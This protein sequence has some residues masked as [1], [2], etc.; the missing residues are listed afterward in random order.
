[1]SEL[2]LGYVDLL[3]RIKDEVRSARRSAARS[4]NTELIVLYWRIGQLIL[5]RQAVEGWGTGVIGRLAADLRAEFP[6]MRGL[7]QRNLLYMR[8]FAAAFVD[9][10]VQ[11]PV[12]Q[13]PWGHVTVLLERTEGGHVRSWYAAQ[14][15]SGGWSRA[16]LLH[17]ISTNRHSRAGAFASNF[18]ETLPPAES[19]LAREVFHDPYDL[20]FLALDPGY[21]ERQLEDALVGRLTSFIAELG[22]GFSFVGRQYPLP[23]G[24]ETY[25]LDLLFFHLGLRRFVVFELKVGTA[26]PEHLGK[27]NFYVNAVDSLLRREEHGDG[28]TIGILLAADRD[29]VVVE[30]SLRGLGTPLAVST[31]RTHGS[32]PV[33]VRTGL[34][35]Q[36]QL[37][38]VVRDVRRRVDG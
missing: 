12:A 9:P 3:A 27:L 7:S 33:E 26:A 16:T 11:Q 15:V 4:V 23:V 20:D 22:A 25:Y 14:A 6:E 30:Y 24:T 13:L 21:T 32:L 8:A 5:D 37:A 17:H 35:S 36:D 29:D 38:E 19:D 1:M 10:I 2:S 28:S 18:P 31:Y 34:P